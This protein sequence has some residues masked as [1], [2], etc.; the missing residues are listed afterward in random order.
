[1]G[2]GS[3]GVT[4]SDQKPKKKAQPARCAICSKPVD[5]KYTPFCSKRCADVDLHRW[6][7]N[8]YSIAG[9]PADDDAAADGSEQ[10]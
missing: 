3:V 1:M 7:N 8:S 10:D 2:G 9:A 4:A 6:L 5:P